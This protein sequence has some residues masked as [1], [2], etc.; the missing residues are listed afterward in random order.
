MTVST[1]PATVL[2]YHQS[3]AL[4]FTSKIVAIRKH[5][6]NQASHDTAAPSTTPD[7]LDTLEVALEASAFY[8]EG[9][10]QPSDTGKMFWQAHDPAGPEHQPEHQSDVCAV[11]LDKQTGLVWH[12]LARHNKSADTVPQAPQTPPKSHLQ[13]GQLVHGHIN[14]SQRLRHS[15]RH[16]A[17]HLLAATMLRIHPSFEVAAVSMNQAECTVDFRGLPSA[18]QVEQAETQLREVLGRRTLP[19]ET[20]FVPAEQLHHYNLRRATNRSGKVRLVIFRDEHGQNYDVSACGGTHVAQASL[21]APVVVLRQDRIK[22]DLTRVTFMAGEEASHYLST[23]Y[24]QTRSLG[25]E[26]SCSVAEVPKRTAGLVQELKTQEQLLE[27]NRAQL[28]ELLIAS[29]A[30]HDSTR[31]HDD[32]TNSSAYRLHCLRLRCLELSET[33]LMLPVLSRVPTNEILAVCCEQRVGISVGSEIGSEQQHRQHAGKLLRA[34]LER[35]GGKGGG[36]PEL[37]QGICDKPDDFF[38]VLAELIRERT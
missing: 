28:A 26:L 23:V 6:P 29:A 19:L 14:E 27:K 1:P 35:T 36:R 32:H 8:P 30:I 5:H 10:G 24:R 38:E 20:P 12:T 34:A 21:C 3:P 9:G 31:K 25:Q 33:A 15:Q 2:L 18:R 16:S 11:R 4:R 22:G 37:A 17:E 7:T 13:I